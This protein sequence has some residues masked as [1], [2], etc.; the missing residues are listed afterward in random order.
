VPRP[1]RIP[2]VGHHLQLFAAVQPGAVSVH[3]ERQEPPD[4]Q[5][6]QPGV[7]HTEDALGVPC[8]DPIRVLVVE[9]VLPRIDLAGQ[10]LHVGA[11]QP[12]SHVLARGPQPVRLH[13]LAHGPPVAGQDAGSLGLPY[14]IDRRLRH[15]RMVSEALLA[16]LP[17]G[18]RIMGGL[19]L[20]VGDASDLF[21]G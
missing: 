6:V 11:G 15:T 12:T 21:G 7:V 9:M 3:L 19:L 18:C 10:R 20:L 2:S 1:T 16:G 4:G 17:F 5:L 8:R 13:V 14:S